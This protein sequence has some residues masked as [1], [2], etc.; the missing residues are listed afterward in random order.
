M[1]RVSLFAVETVLGRGVGGRLQCQLE[2]PMTGMVK[3]RGSRVRRRPPVLWGFG[4]LKLP[5]FQAVVQGRSHCFVTWLRDRPVA[6]A[7]DAVL[8]SRTDQVHRAE[9]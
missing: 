7:V 3:A 8:C 4:C 5:K 1:A 2:G 9:Q 6:V